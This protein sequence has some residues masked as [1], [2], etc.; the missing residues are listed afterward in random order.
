MSVDNI[1]VEQFD[2][3]KTYHDIKRFD[4]EHEYINRFAIKSLKQNVKKHMCQAYVLLD[5]SKNDKFIGYYNVMT[6]SINKEIFEKPLS[7]STKQIPVLRLVMLG[8]D[9]TYKNKGLGSKLLKHCLELTLKLS[10]HVGIAG[11]YL[12]AEDKKHDY[13][14]DRGF[15]GITKPNKQNI[16]PMFIGIETIKD[17][18]PNNYF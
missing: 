17:A 3:S 4:C 6:F 11:L 10:K 8:V 5:T 15:S 1:V 18:L 12:D 2:T 16:L 9:K 13:Y 14:R 7:G